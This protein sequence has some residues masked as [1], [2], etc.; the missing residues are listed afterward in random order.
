MTLFS[1]L[2]VFLFVSILL[3]LLSLA[4]MDEKL[5]L[6][7]GALTVC[8]K[9][10][11]YKVSTF[12][13]ALELA[14]YVNWKTSDQRG[15]FFKKSSEIKS[16]NKVNEA[17]TTTFAITRDENIKLSWRCKNSVWIMANNCWTV[18]LYHIRLHPLASNIR[19][20]L[21]KYT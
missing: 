10:K 16:G 2:P 4:K 19:S 21:N 11:Q 3:V 12:L 17:T 7:T 20:S 9:T 13:W 1:I 18:V 6:K 15:Y 14:F 5:Y 8:I